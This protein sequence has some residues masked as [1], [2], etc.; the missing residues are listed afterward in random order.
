MLSQ[1]KISLEHPAFGEAATMV[2]HT[3]QLP[4]HDDVRL[5]ENE[6]HVWRADL[7]R[8][9]EP[10]EQLSQSLSAEEQNRANSYRFTRDRRRFVVRRALLRQ[11]LARY[12]ACE[13]DQVV[14]GVGQYAKP[15][16]VHPNR[17]PALEFNVSHTGGV[18]VF[19]LTLG[20]AVGIDVE[21]HC[22][23][24][25]L[26][27]AERFYTPQELRRLTSAPG[28]ARRDLFLRLW[29]C[30]EAALK[31]LGAGLSIPLSAVEV[32]PPAVAPVVKIAEANGRWQRVQCLPLSSAADGTC[33][34]VAVLATTV[35]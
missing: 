17:V 19:A 28:S 1:T 16:L 2:E 27:I 18:A 29:T 34:T 4:A 24:E 5:H 32:S 10:L 6:L 33:T 9:A 22:P 14:L 12:A 35:R 23:R 7:D 20:R 11:L 31:A 8:I 13:P 25:Y 15:R 3:L 21:S 30:K 26:Q